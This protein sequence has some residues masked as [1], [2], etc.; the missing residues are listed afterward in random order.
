MQSIGIR[1]LRQNASKY[2]R[3]V[4][5]GEIV[6]VTDRGEPVARLVPIRQESNYERM[7]AEGRIRPGKGDL[8]EVID[9]VEPEPGQRPLSEVVTEM[10]ADERY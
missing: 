8:L 3:A 9:P 10:R 5:R 2:L 6:E 4:R 1:E 7:V